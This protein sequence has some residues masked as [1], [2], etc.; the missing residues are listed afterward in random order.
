M[1]MS[2][3]DFP[4]GNG[5]FQTLATKIYLQ[6]QEEIAN[7]ELPS[8]THLVRRTLAKRFKVS[9]IPVTEA[10]YRLEQDGLVESA[11][12]YGSRV[13]V[14]T[15]EA[16]KNDQMLRE[17]LECQAA[18]LCAEN[19]TDTQLERLLM[20][21]KDL[22]AM[23]TKTETDQKIGMHKHLEFHLYI[24][25]FG[26]NQAIEREV[27]RIWRRRLMR[28]NW[29]S[30]KSLNIP[31]DWHQQLVGAIAKRDPEIAEKEMRKHV[32]FGQDFDAELLDL[33]QSPS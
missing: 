23:M 22:D 28:W 20:M 16:L 2:S 4:L 12:M 6:L 7:G 5:D 32:R 27:H 31:A 9:P 30:A 14:W 25:R 21:A 24:A 17:A 1:N 11:P 13:K 29:L 8:G 19:V 33:A 18:R 3:G 15:L 10:L 26:G